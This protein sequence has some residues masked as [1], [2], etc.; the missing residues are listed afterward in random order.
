LFKVETSAVEKINAEMVVLDKEARVV[1][2]GN[3]EMLAPRR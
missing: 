2:V 3:V 1:F